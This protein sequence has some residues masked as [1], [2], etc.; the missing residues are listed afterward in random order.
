MDEVH[1]PA[2]PNFAS[3]ELGQRQVAEDGVMEGCQSLAVF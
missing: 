2:A 1:E 3:N